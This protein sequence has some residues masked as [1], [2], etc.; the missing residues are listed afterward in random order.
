[1]GLWLTP[2]PLAAC[3]AL[4][5]AVVQR[6]ARW[7]WATDQPV[8]A[9]LKGVALACK[10]RAGRRGWLRVVQ[11]GHIRRSRRQVEFT[12]RQKRAAVVNAARVP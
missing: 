7:L 9:P 4:G 1:M 8:K 5:S 3:L 2:S 11:Q 12:H 10:P 6:S